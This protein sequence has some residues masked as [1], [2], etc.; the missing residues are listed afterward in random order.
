MALHFSTAIE[1][2]SLQYACI[3]ELSPTGF[4]VLG[5]VKTIAVL[6]MGW[7][8][9]DSVITVKVAAGGLFAVCGMI[10]YSTTVAQG[11]REPMKEESQ[12]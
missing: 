10:L 8:F 6:I 3:A 12:G 11:T 9:F 2:D 4:Q 1:I 5:H 7:T